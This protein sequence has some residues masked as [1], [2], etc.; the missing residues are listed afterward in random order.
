VKKLALFAFN[1]E[2]MCFMHVLLNALDLHDKGY[3]VKVIIEGAACR[4]VPDLVKEDSPLFRLSQKARSLN[5]I[6]GVCRAC[7]N[8]MGSLDVAKEH[9]FRLL[10]D[11]SGHPAMATYLGAGFGIISF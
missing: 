8:K 11:M 7:S 9:G 5:L 3:E 10:D 1:G 6:E 4:L 2:S